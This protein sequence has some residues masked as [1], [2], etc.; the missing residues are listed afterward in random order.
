MANTDNCKTPGRIVPVVDV[1]RCEAKADCLR[2][3]P[4][5]V[6]DLA[7]PDETTR[8][9][10]GFFGR[11]KLRVHGGKQALVA[12]PAACEGCGLCV[13]ACPE[14]AISLRAL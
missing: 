9:A 14:D 10:L 13:S 7:V 2:V 12:R 1:K 5:G 6:F 3:C 11:L 4:T 8:A